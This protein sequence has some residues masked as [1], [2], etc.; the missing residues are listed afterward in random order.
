MEGVRLN[1]VDCMHEKIVEA[2]LHRIIRDLGEALER[3]PPTITSH[4]LVEGALKLA[5]GAY[6]SSLE[7]LKQCNQGVEQTP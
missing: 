5:L 2:A 3:M 4:S 7:L 6:A 1:S